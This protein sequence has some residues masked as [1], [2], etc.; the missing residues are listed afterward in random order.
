[1]ATPAIGKIRETNF[2]R[3]EEVMSQLG[4]RNKQAFQEFVVRTGVPF[5]RLSPRKIVF[6]EVSLNQ[7]LQSRVVGN[8]KN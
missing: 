7:W 6:E 1:M 5:I 4:Y 3:P 8:V 2:L